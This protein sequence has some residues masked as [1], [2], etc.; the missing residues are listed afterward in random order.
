MKLFF[1]LLGL[2]LV[3][4]QSYAQAPELPYY[5]IQNRFRSDQLIASDGL[6]TVVNNEPIE[7]W[8]NHWKITIVQRDLIYIQHPNGKYLTGN[9]GWLHLVENAS[10]V[11][12]YWKMEPVG[13]NGADK[14]YIYLNNNGYD[15]YLN[16]QKGILELS[17]IDKTWLTAQWKLISGPKVIAAA[18]NKIS[19]APKE[20]IQADQIQKPDVIEHV[21]VVEDDEEIDN[22]FFNNVNYFRIKNRSAEES[23]ALQSVIGYEKA[24]LSMEKIDPT[25]PK[26]WTAEKN[27]GQYW[28][29]LPVAKVT[30][31]KQQVCIISDLFGS[32]WALGVNEYDEIKMLPFDASD[33]AQQ[34]N[35]Y[36]KSTHEFQLENVKLKSEG[37]TKSSLFYEKSKNALF[38]IDWLEGKSKNGHW[39]F[40]KIE[41]KKSVLPVPGFGEGNKLMFSIK[42]AGIV[43]YVYSSGDFFQLS[44]ICLDENSKKEEQIQFQILRMCNGFFTVTMNVDG[45]H[46]MWHLNGLLSAVGTPGE[47]EDDNGF[48]WKLSNDNGY[49]KFVNVKD[50]NKAVGIKPVKSNFGDFNIDVLSIVD[51]NDASVQWFSIK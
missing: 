40:E 38:L 45:N 36:R 18:E 12:D 11:G 9:G 27:H 16:I 20:P 1:A 24:S 49:Y 17:T 13:L 51:I 50:P 33:Q 48:Q 8:Y 46:F 35:A 14:N 37:K 7:A 2:F 21:Q 47:V 34:W 31:E 41:A 42:G 25:I 3:L 28:R 26:G 6:Y 23:E 4:T 39:K 19:F 10:S 29:V 30:L 44:G 5:Q 22:L 32:I 43:P 15:T